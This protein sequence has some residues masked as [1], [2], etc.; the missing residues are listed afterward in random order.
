MR[1]SRL[2]GSVEGVMSDHDSYSDWLG[3]HSAQIGIRP[4]LGVIVLEPLFKGPEYGYKEINHFL[5]SFL[6]CM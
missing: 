5:P 1:E 2:S 6:A 4:M 3:M